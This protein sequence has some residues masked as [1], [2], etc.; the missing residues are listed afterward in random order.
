MSGM[1][2]KKRFPVHVQNLFMFLLYKVIRVESLFII[3]I[4]LRGIHDTIF[5]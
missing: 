4:K 3:I 1:P 2:I 5:Y